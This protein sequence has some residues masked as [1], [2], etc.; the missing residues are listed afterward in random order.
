MKPKTLLLIVVVIAVCAA[1]L[2][3]MTREQQRVVEHQKLLADLSTDTVAVINSLNELRLERGEQRLQIRR[4]SDDDIWQVVDKDDFPADVVMIRNLLQTLSQAEKIEEMSS[5]PEDYAKLG[6]ADPD[7]DEG[8]GILLEIADAEQRRTLIVGNVAEHLGQGQYVRIPDENSSW[9]INRRLELPLDAD[10][11]LEKY[12]VTI[13]PEDLHR[14]VITRGDAT[15]D[16]TTPSVVSEDTTET[17]PTIAVTEDPL[18]ATTITVVRENKGDELKLEDIPEGRE[19]KNDYILQQ[20]AAA[21]DY[22]QFKE[23]FPKDDSFLLP[24]GSINA[25]FTTFDGLEFTMQSYQIDDDSYAT[26]AF[27]YNPEVAERYGTSGLTTQAIQDDNE[28][29]S[30]LH[31]KW[32]YK[33]LSPTYDSLDLTL[34]DLTE[35]T[36]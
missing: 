11:W 35:E 8:A 33:L 3:M 28:Y 20:V 24:E 23:V 26:V 9:L 15:G 31:A 6:V 19:L 32:Y 30:R 1:A 12:I 18:A 2:V 17:T 16:A 5:R 22:L 25:T 7:A 21:V 27:G 29:L 4:D 34:E 14:I 13:V 36:E 10:S